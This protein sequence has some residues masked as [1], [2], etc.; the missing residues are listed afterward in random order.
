MSGRTPPTLDEWRELL[1]AA[2]Y[3]ELEATDRR[4]L[5]E[6]LETDP[7]LAAEWR[8]LGEA[9]QLLAAAGC[10]EGSMS[11][12]AFQLPPL[13]ARC[14]ASGSEDL[15]CAGRQALGSED[16]YGKSS[17]P[18]AWHLRWWLPAAGGFAA[19][20][21]LFVGFL[22]A[23]LRVDH[24]P[25]GWLVGFAPALEQQVAAAID[26]AETRQEP[27]TAA[28]LPP[29]LLTREEFASFAEIMLRVTDTRLTTLEQRQQD[30][31]AELA[32]ALYTALAT[33]QQRQYD[34]LRLRLQLVAAGWS[35]DHD[36]DL[37][38][39]ANPLGDGPT[40]GG[41]HDQRY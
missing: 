23:G 19:A 21:A 1:V 38:P 13:P 30:V 22:V 35:Q 11:P 16:I 34:D 31:Q 14:Q 10:R 9:R 37:A 26:T 4:R 20:A 3:D 29:D 41:N 18:E 8:E 15:P 2:L 5:D 12:E 27:T 24:T 40:D 7:E 17:D 39:A 28:A 36:L 32:N 25:Q 33:S 6:R